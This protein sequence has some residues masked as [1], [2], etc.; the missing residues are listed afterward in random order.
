[1]FVVNV[2]HGCCACNKLLDLKNGNINPNFPKKEN[3]YVP[4]SMG[5]LNIGF[6]ENILGLSVTCMSHIVIKEN[7]V[8]FM[9]IGMIQL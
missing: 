5:T 2:V 9:V 8:G 3:S 1:M 7:I 4:S 6:K